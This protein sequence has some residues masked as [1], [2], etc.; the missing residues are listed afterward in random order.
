MNDYDRTERLI[1]IGV[2]VG[3]VLLAAVLAYMVYAGI[4]ATREDRE[5]RAKR[6][7]ACET[8]ED[9]AMRTLCLVKG[10]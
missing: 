5:W 2:V 4:D 7:A 8:V 10:P 9:Q 3:M 6:A 1:L